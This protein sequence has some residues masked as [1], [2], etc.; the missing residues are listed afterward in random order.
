MP[1]D[2]RLIGIFL[3]VLIIL[4][5]GIYKFGHEKAPPICD[6]VH[7]STNFSPD[8]RFQIATYGRN[9]GVPRGG[10]S[11]H[12]ALLNNEQTIENVAG[13]VYIVAG[14]PSLFKVNWVSN[15]LVEISGPNRKVVKISKSL[16][17]ISFHYQLE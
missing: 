6:F 13:N 17:D 1:S 10:F 11:T 14:Y 7:W 5:L 12:V 8:R 15:N 4:S 3:S 2:Y 9:C 16:N